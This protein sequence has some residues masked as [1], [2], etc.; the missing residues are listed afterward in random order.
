[1]VLPNDFIKFSSQNASQTLEML[2]G[3]NGANIKINR[4]WFGFKLEFKKTLA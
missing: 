3:G 4:Q 2:E 1:M